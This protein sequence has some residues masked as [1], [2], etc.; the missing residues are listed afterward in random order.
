MAEFSP[1]PLPRL[2]PKALGSVAILTDDALA[3][4]VGVSMGFTQ[5]GGG[6]SKDPFASLNLG[7]HVHDDAADVQ[8][9][10]RI[11]MAALGFPQAQ[12]VVPNQVH[13]QNV[14]NLSTAS[15]ADHQAA[16]CETQEGADALVV[17]S[18]NVAALLCF[19]DCVP[20]VA[21]SPT[22]RA[23]VI[24]A[25]W[26]GAQGGI[27]GKTL[28][29]MA[30]LDCE[31]H[32]LVASW[33]LSQTNVYVGPYIHAECFQVG[34]DVAELFLQTYGPEA[35]LDENHVD[36]GAAL[37]VDAQ[38]QGVA[39]ER[40]ADAQACTVCSPD[41]YYSYRASGGICGRHGA[42]AVRKE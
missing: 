4:S 34:Q 37:R 33:V 7:S 14:V 13:G 30:Q 16:V 15:P 39:L 21:V 2:Q 36:L 8:E 23:A 24:H 17:S 31:E 35:L 3:S 9:N 10:R 42:F 28:Q 29:R 18:P 6:K 20:V 11:L 38:R 40:I 26:R 32:Q 27:L 5:R 1:L 19:A 12:L 22:G 41:L 25:G